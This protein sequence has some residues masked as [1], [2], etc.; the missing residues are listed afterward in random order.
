MS[1]QQW[2]DGYSKC[3]GLVLFG[4]SVDID[5]HGE[6]VGGDTLLMVFNADHGE[7]VPF[8]LPTLKD[9]DA[10]QLLLDT[11]ETL[12]DSRTFQAGDEYPMASASLALFRLESGGLLQ[13][14][15]DQ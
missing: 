14:S 12:T 8:V 6:E 10:W 11:S 2:N 13:C 5:Q 7:P 9:M 3:V 4:D 15:A 1:E